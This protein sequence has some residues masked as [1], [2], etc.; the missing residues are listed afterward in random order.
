MTL[1]VELS[2]NK[3]TVSSSLGK[4]KAA[5]ILD[6][7][8]DLLKEAIPLICFDLGNPK[9]KHIRAGAAKIVECVSE[10]RPTLVEP[11]LEKIL[12]G[13]KAEEPQTKWMIFM[14][15]GYS[16]K[17]NPDLAGK[18]LPF[19]KK[20]ILEKT[21]GQ[22]CLVGAIDKY[23]GF[24]GKTSK[25]NAQKSYKLLIES[26]DNVI[27]N[28]ADWILEGFID[29]AEYMNPEQKKEILSIANEYIDSPKKVTQKRCKMLIEKCT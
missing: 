2:N 25:E 20:Y 19:A 28:E 18:G 27:M 1:L 9:S 17:I 29:I 16:A 23:L 15:L 5:E 6:G 4:E 10:K 7:N 12:P 24:L 13:L 26:I 14:T 3:G 21:D 22:L 11:F 8:V